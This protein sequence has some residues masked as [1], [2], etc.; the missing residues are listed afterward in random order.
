MFR[1][2]APE[3]FV[4]LTS[5]VGGRRNPE[6]AQASEQL[7]AE[8]V[9]RSNERFL[10]ARKPRFV[11]VKKWPRAIPQYTL[12]HADRVAAA[13]KLEAR[14]PGLV[15]CSNWRGGVSISDCITSGMR[16]ADGLHAWLQAP[17]RDTATASAL[18]G[19][20]R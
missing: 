11:V 19:T 8:N 10:G 12:G 16:T 5:F 1:Y 9:M 15:F 18:A 17:T 2:R 6:L 20:V 3:G 7:I 13:A 14:F 4:L